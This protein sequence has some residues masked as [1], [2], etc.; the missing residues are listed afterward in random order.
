MNTDETLREELQLWLR[1][2]LFRCSDA[3]RARLSREVTNHYEVAFARA[4]EEGVPLLF[5]HHAA[6]AALGSPAKFR[7]RCL[8]KREESCVHWLVKTERSRTENVFVGIYFVLWAVTV[9]GLAIAFARQFT[10]P[11]YRQPDWSTF[12]LIAATLL[13]G[14]FFGL[15]R[16]AR[17]RGPRTAF[18]VS[19]LTTLCISVLY[20]CANSF[21]RDA[22]LLAYLQ[23]LP[24]YLA[25]GM[26]LH[27]PWTRLWWK[28]AR[29][30]MP[31]A[32]LGDR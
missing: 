18:G 20:W 28:L 13:Y 30:R 15:P 11:W 21:A 16:I 31:A 12:A 26:A 7:R 10:R 25:F 6:M 17:W 27:A 2:A 22:N 23:W 29:S 8:S 3:T 19:L 14:V 24:F 32:R 4:T 1:E 9:G 5:A